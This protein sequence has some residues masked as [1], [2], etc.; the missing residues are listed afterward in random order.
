[1]DLMH[2]QKLILFLVFFVWSIANL[3]ANLNVYFGDPDDK[4]RLYT[5]ISTLGLL[6]VAWAIYVIKN[7]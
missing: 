5:G 7:W 1:M 6:F 2:L 4:D 3:F